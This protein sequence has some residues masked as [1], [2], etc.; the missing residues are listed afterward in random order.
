MINIYQLW[1]QKTANQ[2]ITTNV[3]SYDLT[4]RQ[5]NLEK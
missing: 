4:T 1:A 3:K 2:E 5:R